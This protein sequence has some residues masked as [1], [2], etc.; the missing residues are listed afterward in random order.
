[1]ISTSFAR[2]AATF[3]SE[4]STRL[5]ASSIE[6]RQ[7]VRT[8]KLFFP[9]LPWLFICLF[10]YIFISSIRARALTLSVTVSVPVTV[11][12]TVMGTDSLEDV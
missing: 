9:S 8:S 1:M 3:S 4:K 10:L 12:V 5:M 11:P 2:N 7:S 6:R